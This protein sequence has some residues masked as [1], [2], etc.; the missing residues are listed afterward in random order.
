M[1]KIKMINCP[2]CGNAICCRIG[3]NCLTECEYD[4]YS[5]L[6]GHRSDV[7]CLQ[8][9][10]NTSC[11]CSKLE[12]R[13]SLMK[14]YD[15]DNSLSTKEMIKEVSYILNDDFMNLLSDKDFDLQI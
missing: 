7:L 3:F 8:R 11:N 1:T 15:L 6:G 2:V 10:Y 12:I 4:H 5:D 9:K 13:E 14:K